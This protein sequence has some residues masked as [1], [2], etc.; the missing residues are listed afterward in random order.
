M[1]LGFSLDC[2]PLPAPVSPFAWMAAMMRADTYPDQ[3]RAEEAGQMARWLE[4]L[5]VTCPGIQSNE[6]LLLAAI[7]RLACDAAGRRTVREA[8]AQIDAQLA[9]AQPA[10]GPAN[11]GGYRIR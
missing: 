7:A 2:R 8:L 4:H 11:A 6:P 3:A 5:A 9:R 1:A 10:N